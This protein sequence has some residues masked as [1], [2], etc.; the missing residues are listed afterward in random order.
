MMK[1]NI[2]V[3]LFLL[4]TATSQL[5][6]AQKTAD[7]LCWEDASSIQEAL[8]LSNKDSCRVVLY[9]NEY[10]SKKASTLIVGKA[11]SGCKNMGIFGVGTTRKIKIKTDFSSFTYLEEFGIGGRIR[12]NVVNRSI[13]NCRNLVRV[14][15][16]YLDS[17][18][19]FP[20]FLDYLDND[21]VRVL[22]DYHFE[23]INIKKITK[24]LLKFLKHTS[25]K[26]LGMFTLKGL[27]LSNRKNELFI[28]KR[29]KEIVKIA[30]EKKIQLSFFGIVVG[31]NYDA[32]VPEYVE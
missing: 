21:T 25:L 30:K 28:D 17:T 29:F 8:S 1:L 9:I 12:K 3:I 32:S 19:T 5:V 27:N 24:N 7:A 4:S 16:S 14:G 22:V 2:S 13:A 26:R 31:Y 10:S 20:K 6:Y 11:L 23:N 15:I 18:Y